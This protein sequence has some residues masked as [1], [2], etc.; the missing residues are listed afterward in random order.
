MDAMESLDVKVSSK[1]ERNRF[2][3]VNAG[4]T[5]TAPASTPP[6][7]N[8]LSRFLYLKLI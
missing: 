8:T 2:E 4:L 6:H 7:Q 3:N 1:E 5:V